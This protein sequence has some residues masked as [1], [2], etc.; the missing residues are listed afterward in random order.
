VTDLEAASI[1]IRIKPDSFDSLSLD[2]QA[3]LDL[4][5]SRDLVVYCPLSLA[6]YRQALSGIAG[7]SLYPDEEGA[8]NADAYDLVITDQASHAEFEARML[9]L[10]GLVPDDIKDLIEI[11]DEVAEVVDWQRS[12]PLL[13]YVILKDVQFGDEPKRRA[14]TEDRDFEERGYEILAQGRA[15]PLILQKGAAGQDVYAMLFHT[16]RSTLVYRVGFPVL[17]KNALDEARRLAGLSEAK[18]QPTGLLA[19]R[20]LT[21]ETNY[22]VVAPDGVETQTKTSVDGLLSGVAAPQ[23]GRYSI[24]TAGSEVASS[25]VS[26]QSTAET[27]LATVDALQMKETRVGASQM[28]LKTDRPLWPWFALAGFAML[29]IE[30]WYF[31]K[32]PAGMAG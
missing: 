30:W 13:Q 19:N 7:V 32:R 24:R 29:L 3:F 4:P 25:G 31:Q 9:L 22:T 20:V 16:D 21:P 10:V 15:G 8:G 12:A 28:T 23:I 14:A 26:L 6:S 1:E 18:S 5:S 27:E 2:N 11:T 17:V